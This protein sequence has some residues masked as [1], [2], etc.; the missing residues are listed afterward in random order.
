MARAPR[1]S[2]LIPVYIGTS[3]FGL[4]Y[5]L[6]APLISL[7]LHK[8]G[9]GESLIGAN[10]GMYALG[11]LLVAVSLRRGLAAFGA[12]PVLGAALLLVALTIPTFWLVWWIP[13]WFVLRFLLGAASEA[14][15]V[16]TEA[17]V[18]EVSE[19]SARA[20]NMAIYT[21]ALSVG[22]ALGPAIL[23]VFGSDGA[24][25]Y[26]AGCGLALAA[27]C[28]LWGSGARPP[29]FAAGESGP[30]FLATAASMP[31]ALGATALNAALE[32]SGLS[33]LPIYA[34]QQGWPEHGA[35]LLITVLMV[36]AI[37]LQ[38]PIGWLGDRVPR[39]TL[40]LAL[41]LVSIA[42][43]LIWP[44]AMSHRPA[45]FALLFLWGGAF[46]GIYTLMVTEVG[47]RFRGGDL[48]AAY[49]V[50]SLA[51]GAGALAGP[52]LAGLAL[53][54]TQHGLPYFAAAACIAFALPLAWSIARSSHGRRPRGA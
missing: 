45:A 18:S 52:V 48:I 21:A 5:G 20:T 44:Q 25:A 3:V 9:V 34:V 27:F 23:A 32:T 35:M 46:V 1:P 29:A 37:L 47:A 26:L 14:V 12:W 10:A 16:V 28:V 30:G 7:A 17:W 42:G 15:M 24:A 41:A 31:L 54:F 2:R 51:W 36:G 43:A 13:A 19:A 11:V 53:E 38:L 33:L 6:S 39:P 4:T 40:M 50:M 49:G 8:Q 22:F